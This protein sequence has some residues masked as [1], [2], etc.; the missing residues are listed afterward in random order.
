MMQ[1]LPK[2]SLAYRLLIQNEKQRQAATSST[3]TQMVY[4][5][6]AEGQREFTGY[7]SKNSKPRHVFQ[8]SGKKIVIGN[9]H[10]RPQCDHCKKLGHTID[11]CWQLNGYPSQFKNKGKSV[12]AVV[13]AQNVDNT[14]ENVTQ[15]TEEQFNRL[16]SVI[17]T[18]QEA[19]ERAA[20]TSANVAGTCL[21]TCS[22]SKWIIDSGATDHICN[23]LKMFNSH[24][25]YTKVPNT[26]TIADGKQIVVE[27]IGQVKFYN[28]IILENVLHIPSLKFNLLST[29]K[30]CRDMHCEI[31]F[32]SYMCILQDPSLN[33]SVVLGK[34]T[35]GL[36]TVTEAQ[37]SQT[38][39]DSS[40]IN[41]AD[42]SFIA[43]SQDAKLRIFSLDNI[44]GSF[45][46]HFTS[47]I[48]LFPS[49]PSM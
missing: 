44:K 25:K 35:S 46:S 20:S 34:L 18:Q 9:A 39:Q 36:Y 2:L 19:D 10:K 47:N 11:V 27:H 21:L 49:I 32:T 16:M 14:D 8:H 43:Q 40:P 31:T 4:A 41:V 6:A 5:N 33:L 26:I 30:L 17:S 42:S 28:G 13:Q 1:L 24:E 23:N 12:A 38:S 7:A 29:H 3:A 45:N 22:N 15:L 37:Y 48:K